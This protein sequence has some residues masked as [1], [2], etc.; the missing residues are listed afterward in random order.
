[1]MNKPDP[2]HSFEE[3][4]QR[5]DH[6]ASPHN[7]DEAQIFNSYRWIQRNLREFEIPTLDLTP[8]KTRLQRENR[9]WR[10]YESSILVAR[11]IW[12]PAIAFCGIA[13]ILYAYSFSSPPIRSV[14]CHA[15]GETDETKPSQVWSFLLNNGYFVN[16]PLKR[17]TVIQLTEN[18]RIECEPDTRIAIRYG[19]SRNIYLHQGEILVHAAALPDSTMAVITPWLR[20]DVI[21][22]IFR[23]KI[24]P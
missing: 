15:Y 4:S 10:R 17:K 3:I 5:F 23:V 1:M 14:Q 8:L 19:K 13:L 11:R 12:K 20:T 6:E 9:K 24:I 16:T 7:A 22:T 21:G 2:N 18:S